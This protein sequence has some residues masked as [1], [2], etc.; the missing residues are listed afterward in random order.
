MAIKSRAQR[1]M[2]RRRKAKKNRTQ[3]VG[4]TRKSP[5]QPIQQ[6]YTTTKV[7]PPKFQESNVAGDLTQA[8]LAYKGGKG[9]FDWTEGAEAYTDKAGKFHKAVEPYAMPDIGGRLSQMGEGVSNL[10]QNLWNMEPGYA[11]GKGG[12]LTSSMF[13][14][15]WEPLNMG[16]GGGLGS[17]PSP[18]IS[19][20]GGSSSGLLAPEVAQA[21]SPEYFQAA[22]EALH[23]SVGANQLSSASSVAPQAIDKLGLAGSGLGVGLNAY[24]ISQQG[25]TPGNILGLGGSAVLGLNALGMANAWNPAG[26][27]MLGAGTL[28]SLLDW[29][30]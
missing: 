2:E 17:A 16:G 1:E 5:R 24:D 27:A 25:A 19:T 21:G 28:G 14:A 20:T 12:E 22:Q 8:G 10:G 18:F 7:E 4:A 3:L 11:V 23:P 9:I 13:G 29:E 30:F 26:W 15:P 6:G